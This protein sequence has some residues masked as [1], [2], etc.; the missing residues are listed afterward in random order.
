V[1]K[2][3]AGG[4][5]DPIHQSIL[6]AVNFQS[7]ENIQLRYKQALI[8]EISSWLD[9]LLVEVKEEE[10]KEKNEMRAKGTNNIKSIFQR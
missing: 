7:T 10:E 5:T 4:N 3:F 2:Y 9:S 6:K 8:L 1:V